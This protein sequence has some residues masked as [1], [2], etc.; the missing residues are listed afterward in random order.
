MRAR[1]SMYGGDG[2]RSRTITALVV[3]VD[4]A[5]VGALVTLPAAAAVES[6]WRWLKPSS[7]WPWRARLWMV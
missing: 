3:A 4:L 2:M 1:R 6:P 7:K 5:A